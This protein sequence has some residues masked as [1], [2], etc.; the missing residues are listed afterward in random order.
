M[1]GTNP[2]RSKADYVP[3]GTML[4]VQEVFGTIQ[5][6]GPL[7]GI[8]ATFVRLAGCNL[9][10]TFC[11]TDF[12]SNW[13]NE[14]HFVDLA[15]QVRDLRNALVVLT[16]GEP[17]LQ[18]VV[19]LC[20]Q[21]LLNKHHVQIETAGTVWPRDLESL[22]QPFPAIGVSVVVSPKTKKVHHE[23]FINACAWKYIIP[24]LESVSTEDGLPIRGTQPNLGGGPPRRPP[25][26]FDKSNIFIQPCDFGP[27]Q[28]DLTAASQRACVHIV[29]RFGY[30]LSLQLHKIVGLP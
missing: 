22:L 29:Q 9:R 15:K 20:S 8:P 19:P 10:C 18:D 24:N 6:E 17:L 5:G 30:R 11:D 28:E 13:A 21:L 1:F 7:S 3:N 25:T 26:E 12:E 16:G 14:V 27:G 2:V 23:V 4:R